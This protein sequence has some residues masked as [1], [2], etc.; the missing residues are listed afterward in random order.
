MFATRNIGDTL[1]RGVRAL[2][3]GHYVMIDLPRGT[4]RVGLLGVTRHLLHSYDLDNVLAVRP[5]WPTSGSMPW[6][7]HQPMVD[8]VVALRL[9][10][11]TAFK[12]AI[13]FH[14]LT[15]NSY[16]KLHLQY[17]WIPLYYTLQIQGL[18]LVDVEIMLT[19][20]QKRC[21]YSALSSTADNLWLFSDMHG[22][23]V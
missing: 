18:R 6:Y 14:E 17:A 11:R 21:I 4:C 22:A 20:T 13:E 15:W 8:G 1:G 10:S 12:I 19:H 2:G 23:W 5:H 3:V 7:L 16:M 9:V